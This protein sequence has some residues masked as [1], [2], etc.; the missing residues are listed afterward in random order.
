MIRLRFTTAIRAL[1]V[2]ILLA[3]GLAVDGQEKA[4]AAPR[5]AP[6]KA[7]SAPKAVTS[8]PRNTPKFPD[9]QTITNAIGAEIVSVKLGPC[10]RG[11]RI[12]VDVKSIGDF[13]PNAESWP[14]TAKGS[15]LFGN[16]LVGLAPAQFELRKAKGEKGEEWA[17]R[18]IGDVKA[19]E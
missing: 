13:D 18:Y 6:T 7:K 17:A 15:C 12:A 8:V 19:Q 4:K 14:V 2:F 3:S 10:R 11:M 1:S 9:E 5:S 16:T